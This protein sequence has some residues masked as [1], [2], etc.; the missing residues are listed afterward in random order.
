MTDYIYPKIHKNIIKREPTE[1]IIGEITIELSS[2]VRVKHKKVWYEMLVADMHKYSTANLVGNDEVEFIDM[3]SQMFIGFNEKCIHAQ[4][5][6][7]F[8]KE[9]I[10]EGIVNKVLRKSR[11]PYSEKSR[12][13]T[14]ILYRNGMIVSI[15]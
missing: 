14:G 12:L 10:K 6:S 2:W 4:Q 8:T 11:Y 9:Y 13:L 5:L 15:I 3:I 1:S 7:S